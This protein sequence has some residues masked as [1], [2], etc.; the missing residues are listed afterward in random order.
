MHEVI[1]K[2]K[3]T[4]AAVVWGNR[5]TGAAMSTLTTALSALL[6]FGP[7]RNSILV[8]AAKIQYRIRKCANLLTEGFYNW[9]HI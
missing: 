7:L 5:V 8:Q 1:L 2:P 4:Y 3:L 6:G 9:E